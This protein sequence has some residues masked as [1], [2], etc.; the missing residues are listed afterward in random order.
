ML[1]APVTLIEGT[2]QIWISKI[3]SEQPEAG[4]VQ[5]TAK[6]KLANAATWIDRSALRMTVLAGDLAAD[7]RGCKAPAG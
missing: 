4:I 3:A 7:I 1:D 5:V 2:E 6:L